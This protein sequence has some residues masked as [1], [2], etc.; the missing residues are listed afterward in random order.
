MT[1]TRLGWLGPAIVIAGAAV[2]SVGGWYLVRAKPRAGDVIDTIAVDA[3]RRL[4]LRA[5][6]G[7]GDRTFVELYDGDA[8]R[9]QA[10]VPH[11]VGTAE[12]RALAWSPDTVSVRV[13]RDGRAEVFAIGMHDSAKLGGFRLAVEHEPIHTLPAGPITLT[14]HVRSYEFV[15][16]AGWHQLVGVE[17]KSGRAL[18]KVDL[19][20][21][22]VTAARLDGSTIVVEQPPARRAFDVVT[23]RDATAAIAGR[24][25]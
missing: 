19:G 22:D 2:A 18:W 4:V 23:G 7:A 8:L 11:Y 13:D 6:A 3:S 9:W 25:L 16:G 5:E 20:A 14:D 10:L 21:A 1:R 24:K 17:L 12:R 15:G